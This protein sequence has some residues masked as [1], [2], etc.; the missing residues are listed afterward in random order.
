MAT[1]LVQS[2]VSISN[3]QTV[4]GSAAAP[5]G[6]NSPGVETT[7]CCDGAKLSPLPN[8]LCV[9]P[10]QRIAAA[11]HR[12]SIEPIPAPNGGQKARHGGIAAVPSAVLDLQ[13]RV[14]HGG[15]DGCP[16]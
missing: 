4:T 9:V 8:R 5:V 7:T 3:R 2:G 1:L 14:D 6:G 12:R 10:S 13:F 15:N 11:I 16:I